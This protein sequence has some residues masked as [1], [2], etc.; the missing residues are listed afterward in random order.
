MTGRVTVIPASPIQKQ[1]KDS[2][3]T[4]RVAAYCRVSTEH[5]EQI[6]SFRNQVEYYTN[7]I[8]ENPDWEMAGIFADEGISGTGTRKRPGFQK[9]I[10]ACLDGKVDRVITKSIS[11]FARNTADCLW[12]SR[13]L[14]DCGVP[15]F[16]EKEQIDTMTASGE[17]LFTILSSLAQEESRNISENTR[18]GIRSRFQQGTPHINTKR[19]LG[20]D[21]GENGQLVINEEQARVVRRIFR[22]FLEGWTLTEISHHLIGDAVPGVTGK[23][24]WPAV[25]I[26][27]M[28]RNEKYKGDLL[29]QKYYTVSYLTREQNENDGKLDR[30]YVKDAHEAIIDGSDWEAAQ[31]ELA[32]RDKFAEDHGIRE[33][34][35]VDTAF[36]GRVFCNA[37]GGH[38]V[39]RRWKGIKE[40]F[41]KCCNTRKENGGTCRMENIRESALRNAFTIAWND[42]VQHRDEYLPRWKQAEESGNA[43]EQLRAKQMQELTAEGL[44]EFEIPELTRMVLEEIT[45]LDQKNFRIRFLD[46][47]IQNVSLLPHI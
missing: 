26:R 5:E 10:Q 36:L 9:M 27:R 6:G 18:W 46:G 34:S 39:R 43:L 24:A 1:Q 7:L 2:R 17:L 42:M 44:L 47:T 21:K 14:R 41:W 35:S 30:Y 28:L 4:I 38:L 23:A 8:N 15:I 22:E 40:P 31:L 19:F 13:K 3:K 20:Y 25:T 11:R 12:Y 32:R 45:V 33:S 29:M 16:F 37:C